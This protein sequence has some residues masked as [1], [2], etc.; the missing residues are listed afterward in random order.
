MELQDEIATLREELGD[1]LDD[2]EAEEEGDLE[3][4]EE[5]GAEDEEEEQ[6]GMEEQEEET[7]GS[8]PTGTDPWIAKKKLQGLKGVFMGE[9]WAMTGMAA[10][11]NG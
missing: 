1:E 11:L 2:M 3:K 7:T 9:Q 4:E 6:Q 5:E 8:R 10:R